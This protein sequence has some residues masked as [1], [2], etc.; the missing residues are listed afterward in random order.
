MSSIGTPYNKHSGV[1]SVDAAEVPAGEVAAVAAVFTPWSLG[2]RPPSTSSNHGRPRRPLKSILKNTNSSASAGEQHGG[3]GSTERRDP[4]V[5]A[6]P[7]GD[8]TTGD[9]AL[10]LEG[11]GT[12]SNAVGDA[13]L[14]REGGGTAAHHE[15]RPARGLSEANGGDQAGHRPTSGSPKASAS[16]FISGAPS[17]AAGRTDGAFISR[18][19]GGTA[20]RTDGGERHAPFPRTPPETFS[21]SEVAGGATPEPPKKAS[22]HTKSAS[23]PVL[24]EQH[25]TS[26]S[27][28]AQNRSASPS[29]SFLE[30]AG[31]AAPP[32][33][34]NVVGDR[35]GGD[36]ERSGGTTVAV[37]G[38]GNE[39][40]EQHYEEEI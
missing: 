17:G 7:R 29:T 24:Q 4:N 1:A 30:T 12:S 16:T 23:T 39:A 18:A 9:V 6:E 11:G 35:S 10:P 40:G 8:P 14:P 5:L 34:G 2:P 3:V 32:P 22:V 33:T 26:S 37:G 15:N 31:R 27:S 25:T 19:P 21:A 28:S 36:G 13:A 20:Q 38:M